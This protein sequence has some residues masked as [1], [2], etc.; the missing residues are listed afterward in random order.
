MKMKI[1]ED[2]LRIARLLLNEQTN[3]KGVGKTSIYST[4]DKSRHPHC[5]TYKHPNS[6][7]KMAEMGLVKIIEIKEHGKPTGME[8]HFFSYYEVLFSLKKLNKYLQGQ[9][10]KPSIKKAVDSTKIFECGELK[11]NLLKTTM[12]YKNKPPIDISPDN[13][14]IKFLVHLIKSKGE[15]VEYVE[16]AKN[17]GLNC[18]HEGVSNKEVARGVQYL[19]RDARKVLKQAGL[20]KEEVEKMITAK[21]NIGYKLVCI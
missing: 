15:V 8:I 20:T 7:P 14:I 13:D 1:N 11:I 5:P 12:Q 4:H 6:V 3:K 10:Q 16:I 17:L 19:K 2:I 9:S 18:H 21:K